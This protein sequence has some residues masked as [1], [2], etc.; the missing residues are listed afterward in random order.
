[1]ANALKKRKQQA[2][3]NNA[4]VARKLSQHAQLLDETYVDLHG[5]D[6]DLGNVDP[7]EAA[8]RIMKKIGAS[9]E[10][11]MAEIFEKAK[12]A[13]CRALIGEHFGHF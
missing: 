12:T 3:E 13:E 1:M 9:V 4:G 8:S 2:D 11:H 5:S 7:K 10:E 6:L